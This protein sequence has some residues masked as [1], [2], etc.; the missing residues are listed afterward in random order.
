M[1]N[2]QL[3]FHLDTLQKQGYVEHSEKLYQLTTSGKEFANRFDADTGIYKKQAKITVW[4]CAVSQI[5][6]ENAFLVG[7]RHKNPFYGSQGFLAGK[8]DFG[9]TVAQGAQR[10]LHEEAGLTGIAELV[11]IRHYINRNKETNEV[12]ED[13]FMFLCVVRN[14][15]GIA[16]DGDGHIF[17]WVKESDFKKKITKPFQSY[18][19]F[20]ADADLAQSFDG[21]LTFGEYEKFPENF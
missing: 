5:D 8:L 17:E 2:S 19:Q 21:T 1:E 16:H 7:T 3:D 10:E 13:K 15:T 11:H 9:E 18:E 6:G 14:P 4:V 20:C 12:I